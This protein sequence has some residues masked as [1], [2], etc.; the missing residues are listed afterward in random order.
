MPKLIMTAT[1]P[2]I[3]PSIFMPLISLRAPLA[4]IAL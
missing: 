2:I 4:P 3:V 1:K